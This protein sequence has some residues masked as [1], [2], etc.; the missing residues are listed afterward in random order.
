MSLA[1]QDPPTD[2]VQEALV[3]HKL[4]P[5][6]EAI[7]KVSDARKV[8]YRKIKPPQLLTRLRA[9]G[10]KA[11]E[12]D[13]R[14]QLSGAYEASPRSD[15]WFEFADNQILGKPA[16]VK[17]PK[18]GT[19]KE[20]KKFF[21]H[22]ERDM[23]K[24]LDIG[25]P[26]ERTVP[27]LHALMER[28][29]RDRDGY[30]PTEDD[31]KMIAD[32]VRLA[33]KVDVAAMWAAAKKVILLARVLNEPKLLK[34]LRES[35]KSR[36]MNVG[37]VLGDVMLDVITPYGRMVVGGPGPNEYDCAQIEVIVDLGGD[38]LYKG[39]AGG[40]GEL[41]RFA[42]CIDLEGDDTYEGMNDALGSATY[43]IGV[44]VDAAGNDK[45]T[46]T[47]RSAGFG[48]A[49]V[50]VF[51]DVAGNDEVKLDAHSGGVGLVGVGI[52]ADL[53]GNDVQVGSDVSFGCGLPAG[54]GLF[55]DVKGDDKRSQSRNKKAAY[56]GMGAARGLR[57]IVVGGVGVCLDLAGNDNY[58]GGDLSCG[59]GEDGGVGIFVDA[60]GDD[61]YVAHALSV[62]AARQGS[63]AVF[64][65]WS[66]K[67]TYN[68]AAMG[69]GFAA[70]GGR[71]FC[72]DLGGDDRYQVRGTGLGMVGGEAMA[73]FW[74]NKGKDSYLWDRGGNEPVGGRLGLGMFLDTGEE[75]D[76]Y[77]RAGVAFFEGV[78]ANGKTLW[79][80]DRADV[81]GALHLFVD[82]K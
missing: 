73:F 19:V 20:V 49:G 69:L 40:A 55:L 15:F 26:L 39:P 1:P 21:D 43:G 71:A 6:V 53:D 29:Q 75:E 17:E 60:L 79:R 56:L 57:G 37:G 63:I 46:A 9:A 3:T 10:A 13:L 16:R 78:E 28:M 72:F 62:G 41:R 22:I 45:Y 58:S 77:K 82:S 80:G 67:D 50:G 31:H 27:R 44:L 18:V 52:F 70:L 7:L 33:T 5:R 34:R 32:E 30:V 74:D 35:P 51:V 42:V 68:T 23:R 66:G 8:K 24:A 54:V 61:V 14:R 47:S 64:Q 65:D 81:H 76:A 12:L 25:K 36:V 2:A 48:A 11:H 4:T 59:A 38:D